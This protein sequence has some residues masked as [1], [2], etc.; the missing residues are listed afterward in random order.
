[1]ERKIGEKVKRQGKE[2]EW[3]KMVGREKYEKHLRSDI[4]RKRKTDKIFL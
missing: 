2:V 4:E 3:E 1:M